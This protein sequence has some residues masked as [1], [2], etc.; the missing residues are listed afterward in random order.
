MLGAILLNVYVTTL[1]IDVGTDM[2]SLD[3]SIYGSNDGKL[4]GL[5]PG[6]SL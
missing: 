1:G 6:Y 4:E 2:G 5:F 3:R